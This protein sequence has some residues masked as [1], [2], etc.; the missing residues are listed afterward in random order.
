MVVQGS[1]ED[2]GEILKFSRRVQTL[3]FKGIIRFI[4]GTARVTVPSD[5]VKNFAIVE[6]KEYQFYMEVP[7]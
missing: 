4:N 2:S 3:P 6:G 5:Y 7:R 1:T